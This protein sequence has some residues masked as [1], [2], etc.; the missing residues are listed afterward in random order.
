[1]RSQRKNAYRKPIPSWVR[2][3]LGFK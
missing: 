3:L 2:V 1:M